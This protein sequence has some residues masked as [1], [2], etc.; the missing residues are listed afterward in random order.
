MFTAGCFSQKKQ[1]GIAVIVAAASTVLSVPEIILVDQGPIEN[2]VTHPERN[3]LNSQIHDHKHLGNI[4]IVRI[5]R[6]G[7]NQR[8]YRLRYH[9][10]CKANQCTEIV[11]TRPS[12]I[13]KSGPEILCRKNIQNKTCGEIIIGGN[14]M[15][16]RISALRM[17]LLHQARYAPIRSDNG[18]SVHARD[19]ADN[20][21]D[22][23]QAIINLG[24]VL[25]RE[26][27]QEGECVIKRESAEADES[28]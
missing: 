4:R 18:T 14:R 17:P 13:S 28:Q 12:H 23:N 19:N 22:N 6:V 26:L 1:N 25:P 5:H 15:T 7:V 27:D 10:I 11:H 2:T 9:G 20:S 21:G 8:N 3:N 16:S 24:P